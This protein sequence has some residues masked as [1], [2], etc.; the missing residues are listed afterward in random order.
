[1]THIEIE[2]EQ[3]KEL[4]RRLVGMIKEVDAE[5]LAHRMFL[6]TLYASG[7]DQSEALMSI[8]T[9]LENPSTRRAIDSKYREM[10]EKLAKIIEQSK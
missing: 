5:L 2:V 7:L 10:E 9:A 3:L 6:E 8:Q 4:V 1:M